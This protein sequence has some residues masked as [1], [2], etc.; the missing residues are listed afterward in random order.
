MRWIR[1]A[2]AC[3]LLSAAP[4][5]ARATTYEVGPGKPHATPGEVPWEALAPGDSVLIYGRGEPYRDKWV[6]CRAG[7]AASPIVVRGIPDATAGLPVID[8]AGATTRPA[9]NY[10]NEARGVI[11]IGGANNPPDVMPAWIVIEGLDIRG[12][13]PENTFTGRNGLTSYAGNAAA[14]YIEKGEHL[15]V[16]GCR[17]HDCSNGL[18]CASQT[19]DLLVEGNRIDDNGNVGSI[20]EHNNYTEA[21][22]IVFQFNWFGPL[23]A[24]AGGNNLKDR[25]AG[26]VIRYNWIEGG[27]RQLDL[28]ESDAAALRD[29]PRY[30][31]TFVYGNVLFETGDDGN[32][33][34]AH[35][36]G[37]GGQT[38]TYRKGTLY[39]HHNTVVSRRTGNTTL[40]RLSSNDEAADVRDNI[41]SVT[42]A[43]HR[44][45]LLDQS[46]TLTATRNWMKTGWVASHSGSSVG[47][48]DAGQITGADPGFV[49]LTG[50]DFALV[51]GSPCVDQAV[52]LPPACLP[53]HAPNWEYVKHQASRPRPDD[54]TPDLGALEWE[55]PVGVA[56]GRPPAPSAGLV[57]TPNPF[58]SHCE[59]RLM[60]AGPAHGQ[61]AALE[62]LDVRG[63]AVVRLPSV[64]PGRW[65]W[66]PPPGLPRGLYFLRLGPL[67][68]RVALAR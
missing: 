55:L 50:A 5:G 41:L 37:D 36:G 60:G 45:A 67:T 30:R 51:P 63:R 10:W 34:I 4:H 25:S 7:T 40:L 13:R 8:G 62:V 61:P 66:T 32:S 17:L 2:L 33:Q 68:R 9:L 54:G 29:D 6:I 20:Y 56:D 28:V 14:I 12:G 3:S 46:G 35:Y 44:L 22:G 21:L 19:S 24:G 15:V 53:E 58:F 11:K 26:T 65:T 18:F 16:R 49:D 48:I 31:E 27:N 43:G 38:A 42:A 23:R 64:E 39:F 47:V 52:A 59:I 1:T 57:A